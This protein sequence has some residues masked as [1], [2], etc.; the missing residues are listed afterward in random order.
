IRESGQKILEFDAAAER[1]RIQGSA[2]TERFTALAAE[3]EALRMEAGETETDLSLQEIED[4]MAE[5][6]QQIKRLG[7][8]NMLAIEEYERGEKKEVL[9]RERATLLE[10]IEK[11]EKMKYEAFMTAFKAIDANFREVFARLTSGSGHLI[12]ENEEDP[13]SGGLS[14]AVQPRDKPVHLLS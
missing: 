2:L 8:V 7:A 4:G 9:S 3:I 10:R 11:F 14:F 6:A 12:L 13:F 5:A 1:H